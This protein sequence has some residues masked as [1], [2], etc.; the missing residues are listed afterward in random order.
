[1]LLQDVPGGPGYICHNG[2]VLSHQNVHQRRLSCIGLPK[3][4][5]P[6]PFGYNAPAGRRPDQ[7]GKLLLH[8]PDAGQQLSPIAVQGNMLRIVQGRFDKG[9]LIKDPFPQALYFL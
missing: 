3:D 1:M 7:P 8:S 4:H 9:D 6:D 2:P 5:G